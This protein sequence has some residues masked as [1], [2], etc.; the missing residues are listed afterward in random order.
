MLSVPRS[1]TA[2]SCRCIHNPLKTP[3]ES[4][5]TPNKK[6]TKQSH[7][8]QGNRD[9]HSPTFKI[10]GIFELLNHFLASPRIS[11]ATPHFAQNPDGV[12]VE[13]LASHFA[14][15]NSYTENFRN[16]FSSTIR[17]CYGYRREM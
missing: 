14:H 2:L 13:M 9:E 6:K 15:L 4:T 8:K 17:K 5:S 7:H 11:K 12:C 1:S 3:D 10:P 16:G